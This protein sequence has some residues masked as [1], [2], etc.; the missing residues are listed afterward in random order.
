MGL[1]FSGIIPHSHWGGPGFDSRRV[2]IF[3]LSFFFS[4]YF[5]SLLYIRL[6]FC[7]FSFFLLYCANAITCGDISIMSQRSFIFALNSNPIIYML[8]RIAEYVL[9]QVIYPVA[10]A[11][12]P[13]LSQ[14]PSPLYVHRAFV[15]R[16][17]PIPV[18]CVAWALLS[19]QSSTKFLWFPSRYKVNPLF[20]RHVYQHGN[21]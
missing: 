21:V 19:C 9:P 18:V 11:R 10:I 4:P 20:G 14:L 16:L 8:A 13:A 15:P 5:I 3:G 12:S 17:K 7:L 1:W 2:H 6:C